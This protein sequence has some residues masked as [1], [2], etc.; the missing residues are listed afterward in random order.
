MTSFDYNKERLKNIISSMSYDG[1]DLKEWQTK[2]RVKLSELLGMDKFQKVDAQLQVEY[3]QKIE[4]ATEIRFTFQSEKG[5][6]V[7]CHLLL[8]DGVENPPV[9]ICLQ[10]HTTG[11]HISLGRRKYQRDS[12]WIENCDSDFCVRAIKEGFAAVALEQRNYGECGYSREASPECHKEALTAFLM[13]RTTIGERVWDVARLIDVLQTS[14]ADRIDS[15]TVC[16]VGNSGGGT[17]TA[18]AA[19]LEERL[20]LAMPS[21]AMCSYM[22]SIG[23]FWHCECNYVPQMANYFTMGD[24]MAMACPKY[25]VQVSGIIDPGF[26]IDGAVE[27]YEQGRR[28]YEKHG[29]GDR[30][31][32]V[33]GDGG[34]RFFADDAWPIVHRFIGR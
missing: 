11:M 22:D 28:V 18:F 19:A 15:N 1:G 24:L 8:P 25:F 30:C 20:T 6:R 32:L 21:C 34:H 12:H 2:A 31:A 5:Y 26:L 13:G 27:V 4:G 33:K 3:E 14:F 16:M 17:A 29:A 7:P 9:M 23:Y 10:G